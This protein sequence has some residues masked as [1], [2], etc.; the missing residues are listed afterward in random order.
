MKK[1]ILVVMFVMLVMVAS[2]AGAV[3]T[4]RYFGKTPSI[5]VSLIKQDPDPIEPGN[6]VE[7]SFKIENNGTVAEDVT[8]EI[9]PEYPFTLLP[10]ESSS[11]YIGELGTSQDGKQSVIL[12]YKLRVAQDAP[13]DDHEI[14][15][16]YKSDNFDSWATLE[17][18]KVKVQTHDAI[19][20]VEKMF[21]VPAVTAPGEKTKLRI[22]L[23]NYATSLLKDIK[24]S[25]DLGKSG[26]EITPFAP[27]GSSN[28]KVISYIEPQA[29]LLAEFELLVDSDAASK[30]YKIPLAIK[31]S[32]V[33]NKNYSK[34]NTVTLVVGVE[35]DISVDI[36]STT[37]YS[38][39]NTGEVT[40]KIVNKGLTD[41][42]FLNVG[43]D[44]VDGYSVLSPYYVYIGNIDSDDYETA[45]FKLNV[46][47]TSEKK[48]VLPL[49]IEYKDA[50]NQDYKKKINLELQLYT[51]SEAKKFGLIK[52]NGTITNIIIVVIVV[53]GIFIYMRWR[54]RK[55]K[56]A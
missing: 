24:L 14:K 54:K 11:K 47:K 28:E 6:Q 13:D 1:A 52:G 12:K 49:T 39:G 44:K 5:F 27:I 55:N 46:K 23:K 19:L 9:V 43:L 35:P 29:N 8:F 16:R 30:A 2:I 36:D 10:E 50:N 21:T 32:D 53:A 22:E 4:T 42:K 40:V 38:A 7:V 56:K 48:I 17:G 25:L 37:I 34:T 31:Y 33:L 18:F 20:A 26:D 3:V 45:D 51:S 41:I 15:V